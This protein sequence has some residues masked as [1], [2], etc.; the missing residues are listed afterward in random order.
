MGPTGTGRIKML[1]NTA[2]GTRVDPN[3][4]EDDLDRKSRSPA[5]NGLLT[6]TPPFPA[7]LDA[8]GRFRWTQYSKILIDRGILS[9]DFLPALEQLCRAHQQYEQFEQVMGNNKVTKGSKGQDVSHPLV[10][11]QA[12][13]MILIRSIQQDFGLTPSSARNANIKPNFGAPPAAASGRQQSPQQ[14]T[15]SRDRGE[16][17][18]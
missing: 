7:V 15:R 5:L 13:L 9:T 4:H 8:V 17:P 16:E 1:P 11:D 2:R 18:F 12:T 14:A 3:V 6:S 10:K